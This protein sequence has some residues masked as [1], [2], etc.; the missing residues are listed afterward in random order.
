LYDEIG[1]K[2]CNERLKSGGFRNIADKWKSKAEAKAQQLGGSTLT[3]QVY[4]AKGLMSWTCKLCDRKKDLHFT[5]RKLCLDPALVA[6][7]PPKPLQVSRHPA[8]PTREIC[9]FGQTSRGSCREQG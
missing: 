7:P 9:L 3:G 4:V 5:G 1:C 8:A 2:Q 6:A